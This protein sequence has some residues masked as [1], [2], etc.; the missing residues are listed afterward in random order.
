MRNLIL[1]LAVMA[2]I[3]TANAASAQGEKLG[4]FPSAFDAETPPE[5]DVCDDHLV[6][7]APVFSSAS[8]P[9][10]FVEIMESQNGASDLSSGF[11]VEITESGYSATYHGGGIPDVYGEYALLAEAIN[12]PGRV[13]ATAEF[14]GAS[15]FAAYEANLAY[16]KSQVFGPD[17]AAILLLIPQTA[18]QL[19]VMATLGGGEISVSEEGRTYT[20]TGHYG[21][22]L[23]KLALLAPLFDDEF[24]APLLNAQPDASAFISIPALRAESDAD[25]DGY[26]NLDEFLYFSSVSC[27]DAFGNPDAVSEELF[28]R[29]ALSTSLTPESEEVETSLAQMAAGL[30][31][32]SFGS[33]T[34]SLTLEDSGLTPEDFAAIDRNAD[35][36]LNFVELQFAAGAASPVHSADADTSGAI[37]LEELLRAIQFFNAGGYHCDM[38]TDDGYAPSLTKGRDTGCPAHASDF[39]HVDGVIELSE[40]LRLVQFY[41]VGGYVSCIGVGEDGFCPT[42]GG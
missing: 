37:E 25:G 7:R 3:M 5:L 15:A 41:N 12:H 29:A 1:A 39:V 22:M 18:R 14:T 8:F 38:A 34:E 42:S 27:D 31:G 21:A 30:L 20:G 26:S 4:V 16:L 23:L 24:G 36:L 2:A 11:E 13:E 40:L 28:V 35:N 19:A 33:G 32:N 17:G 10:G 9:E 6:W